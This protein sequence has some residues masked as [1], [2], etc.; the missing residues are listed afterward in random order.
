MDTVILY[1]EG[2]DP[3]LVQFAFP[4]TDVLTCYSKRTLIDHL[5]GRPELLGA[6]LDLREPDDEWTAFLKSVRQ[7]FPM[8]NVFILTGAE[9][10][11]LCS[12]YP[13]M[14]RNAH[15][16]KL[17][18]RLAVYFA[19]PKSRNR[20][21]YH[22]FCWPLAAS[23]ETPD[24]PYSANNGN[25]GSHSACGFPVVEISAGGAFLEHQGTLPP[26]GARGT[27]TICFQNMHMKST[28]E[29]LPARQTTSSR[30]AGFAVRFTN[31]SDQAT[32]F[33]NRIV[34]DALMSVLLDPEQQPQMPSIEEDDE[35]LVGAGEFSLVV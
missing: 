27:I 33:I 30:P 6:I 35:L 13:C 23:L 18:A 34:Q 8:L 1:S 21:Q 28:C 24:T 16:H 26:S 7:S 5:V 15:E 4:A 17:A 12:W 11:E 29:V 25:G 9:N 31:L 32:A 19:E 14:S 3:N 2:I 20:R 22:R 10:S